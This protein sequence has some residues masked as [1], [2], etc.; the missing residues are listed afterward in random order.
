MRATRRTI[1]TA[2][3]AAVTGAV[4]ALA[5]PTGTALAAA[6]TSAPETSAQTSAQTS[7]AKVTLP[8]GRIAR[9][10]DRGGVRAGAED[11]GTERRIGSAPLV[12]AGGG[13]AALGSA[14]L[15]FAV[16]RRRPSA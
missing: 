9:L 6:P 12:A 15:A 14:S 16:L 1:R 2:T 13:M 11:S 7:A 5:L 4:A 3:V 10:M 8:E